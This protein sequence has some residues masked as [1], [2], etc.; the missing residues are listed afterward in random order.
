MVCLY[1][2]PRKGR[3]RSLSSPAKFVTI[4]LPASR[5]S[6]LYRRAL[7]D[8]EISC[9]SYQHRRASIPNNLSRGACVRAFL[10]HRMLTG[11]NPPCVLVRGHDRD[12][13]YES[14]IASCARFRSLK[15]ALSRIKLSERNR[16]CMSAIRFDHGEGSPR[17]FT[18]ERVFR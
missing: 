10:A 8:V 2:D 13:R 7:R 11:V 17:V 9:E 12:P 5:G 4:Y 6:M 3:V 15:G 1:S 14:D 18:R 16:G